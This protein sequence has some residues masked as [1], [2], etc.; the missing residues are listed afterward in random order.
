MRAMINRAV[1][2]V[3][4]LLVV[5]GVL[6]LGLVH[7]P[8]VQA[9]PNAAIVVDHRHTDITKIPTDWLTAAKQNIAWAYGHTSHGSQLVSGAEYLNRV[10]GVKYKFISNWR[11]IPA[12][13]TPIGLREGDDGS[14]GWDAAAFVQTARDLL[15]EPGN[16]A[17][18]TIF[19]WS[20]CGQQ[21]D[22]SVAT[23]NSYLSMMTQ[24]E[25]EYPNVRFV[26]MTGHTDEWADQAVLNRNNQ[27]VRDY[28]NTHGKILFDFAD[29]ESYLPDGTLY[30]GTPDDQCPWCEAWCSAQPGDCADLDQVTECAHSDEGEATAA[31]KLNC[32][33]KG[34]AWWWLSARLAGWSGSELPPLSASGA[35]GNHTLRVMW[36]ANVSLPVTST[37]RITYQGPAGDQPS[38]ISNLPHATTGYTLTGLT[39]YALYTITVAA[40][41]NATPIATA[42]PL[43]LMPS[44]RFCY[45]PVIWR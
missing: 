17:P 3:A 21:S 35:P 32:K 10:D 28:V 44:D 36:Q 18:G 22:N 27:L 12:Q 9:A 42:A 38:P 26:Y 31:S 37:W 30:A 19:M 13:E 40:L 20:W 43:V 7:R 14:W 16:N 41:S 39:N 45:L 2:I 24:L 34:Q 29:I 33:L 11:A 15:D 4:G 25:G 6:S 23:V 1:W 5:S 8:I